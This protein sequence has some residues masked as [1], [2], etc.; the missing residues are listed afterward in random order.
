MTEVWGHRGL[1]SLGLTPA[2]DRNNSPSLSELADN[3]PMALFWRAMLLMSSYYA[4]WN[5]WQPFGDFLPCE[6]GQLR[7]CFVALLVKDR[8]KN[9]Y[10]YLLK[11]SRQWLLLEYRNKDKYQFK[12]TDLL[13]CTDTLS[14]STQQCLGERSSALTGGLCPQAY[15][16]SRSLLGVENMWCLECVFIM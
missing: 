10:L 6:T 12:S 2:G 3:P 15:A 16:G 5:V 14:K 8:R 4:S 1:V 9:D 13:Y 11:L 7:I